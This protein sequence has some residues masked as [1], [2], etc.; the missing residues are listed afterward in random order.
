MS[1]PAPTSTP[2][3]D[4]DP[5][6]ATSNRERLAHAFCALCVPAPVLGQRIIALCG[7]AQTFNGRRPSTSG[8]VVCDS[9]VN[10]D[11]LECGHPGI[12]AQ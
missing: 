10:A 12:R 8:C 1:Q 4:T 9:L 3:T 11:I 2:Q 7:T 6:P 5:E